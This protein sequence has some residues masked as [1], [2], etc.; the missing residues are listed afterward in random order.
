[1]NLLIAL[2]LILFESASEGLALSGHKA[3]SG[4]LEFIFL[5]V[6]T[7]V[8]FSY[9]TGAYKLFARKNIIVS[10]QPNI[11]TVLGGY[12]LLRFALF[13]V[14]HNLCAGIPMFYIG[15]TKWYD[16]IWQWFFNCS[17]IPSVHFLFMMKL[18]ALLIG[19]T[20]LMG[21]QNGIISKRQ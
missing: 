8:M 20:W 17:G 15:S 4:A 7:L 11:L 16:Q 18:I 5:A 3:L 10:L 14:I 19:I 6:V 21:W 12:I 13:D 1:M 9:T 2:F